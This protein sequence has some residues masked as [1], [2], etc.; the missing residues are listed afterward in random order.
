MLIC[1]SCSSYLGWPFNSTLCFKIFKQAQAW[2]SDILVWWFY[3][4]SRLLNWCFC[5][6]CWLHLKLSTQVLFVEYFTISMAFTWTFLH[7]RVKSKRFVSERWELV[8]DLIVIS[9][10][11][12]NLILPLALSSYWVFVEISFALFLVQDLQVFDFSVSY[13][14][15]CFLIVWLRWLLR[16]IF[17]SSMSTF[18]FL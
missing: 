11:F 17:S 12:C 4:K 18:W 5:T 13:K 7:Y 2:V 3:G 16:T 8:P 1:P 9:L 14:C 15:C 6:H 10:H